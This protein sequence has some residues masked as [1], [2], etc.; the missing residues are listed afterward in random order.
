MGQIFDYYTFAGGVLIMKKMTEQ[1]GHKRIG[2]LALESD[3]SIIMCGQVVGKIAPDYFDADE[4]NDVCKEI[5]RRWNVFEDGYKAV[6]SL[7]NA[8]FTRP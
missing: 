1:W 7:E 8:D 6:P 3:G 2:K 4:V 5:V